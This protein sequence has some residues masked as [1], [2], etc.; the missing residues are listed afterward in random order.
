MWTKRAMEDE[1]PFFK[2][3][4]TSLCNFHAIFSG[5][6]HLRRK[7]AWSRKIG[8]WVRRGIRDPWLCVLRSETHNLLT[9]DM[10]YDAT[11]PASVKIY[12]WHLSAGR[13][14]LVGPRSNIANRAV[15]LRLQT[16]KRRKLRDHITAK[17]CRYHISSMMSLLIC[18]IHI[19]SSEHMKYAS[20]RR[21]SFLHF[22]RVSFH[23]DTAICLSRTAWRMIT[24]Y[25]VW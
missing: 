25:K 10:L 6:C 7:H 20:F 24:E 3:R 21:P 2:R 17:V 11:S 15:Q 12:G 14:V 19:G 22:R 13:R 9:I 4:H 16:P 23:T 1:R 5:P 18:S 8:K